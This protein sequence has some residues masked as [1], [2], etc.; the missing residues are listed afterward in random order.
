MGKYSTTMKARRLKIIYCSD[1]LMVGGTEQQLIELIS[2]IDF[3]Q[4]E[5]YVFCLYS[6]RANRSLHFLAQLRSLDVPVFDFDLDW[7]AKSKLRAIWL[8][9]FEIWKIRP[10]VVQAV[11]YHSNLLSR[12]A[13]PFL[14]ST[15]LIGCIFVPYS[16]RQLWYERI[17]N[18]LCDCIVCN[19]E[20]LL[21]QVKQFSPHSKII[22]IPNGVNLQKFTGSCNKHKASQRVLLFMGRICKQKSPHL[23]VEALGRLAERGELPSD[24]RLWIVGEREDEILDKQIDM[25]VA[26]YSL[27]GF[28]FRYDA[29][30]TPEIF[31]DLSYL[32]VLPS[33][34]ESLPGVILE[35]LATGC[36]IILSEAA[37]QVGV[38]IEA[39]N[40]WVFRTDDVEHLADVLSFV[41]SLPY[42]T[43]QSMATHCRN[44]ILDYDANHMV[45]SYVHLYESLQSRL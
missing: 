13:R 20:A 19:S 23:A 22:H 26:K 21:N 17:S 32:V 41:F 6:S 27:E 12:L 36:P 40:G 42:S 11:N 8:L 4:Y 37:N 35:A 9:I 18:W 14:P 31:Y 44:S 15:Y 24:V 34:W 39:Y 29:T 45:E 33:L 38:V 1:S 30:N 3:E 10:Q 5:V 25:L 16:P 2:R 28:V 43:I 7:S